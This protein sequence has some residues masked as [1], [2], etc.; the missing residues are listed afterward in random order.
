MG[1]GVVV[2][3]LGRAQDTLIAS[4]T[5]LHHPRVWRDGDYPVYPAAIPESIWI[6]GS[7]SLRHRH[8]VARSG[9][10]KETGAGFVIG[11]HS[12]D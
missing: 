9:S 6:N 4:N 1:L 5:Q 10:R 3:R 2:E 11:A 12:R 7:A 8:A